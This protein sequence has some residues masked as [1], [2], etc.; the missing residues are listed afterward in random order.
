MKV[1]LQI[2]PPQPPL[3][4]VKEPA[5]I[6]T[7]SFHQWPH[8]KTRSLT[9]IIT[10]VH[11]QHQTR[12]G[13]KGF[14]LKKRVESLSKKKKKEK[15]GVE[16]ELQGAF[17][18]EKFEGARD[19]LQWEFA[20]GN[21]AEGEEEKTRFARVNFTDLFEYHSLEEPPYLEENSRRSSFQAGVCDVGQQPP[22]FSMQE[23]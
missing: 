22:L 9:T 1:E 5:A 8:R 7:Q 13:R 19:D 3:L 14:L 10:L 17:A 2:A 18:K 16:D 21:F 4:P 15:G 11:G 23:K 6:T 12:R 20:R